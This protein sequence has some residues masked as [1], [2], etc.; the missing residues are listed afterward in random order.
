MV[1]PTARETKIYI[2]AAL[3]EKDRDAF[4]SSKLLKKKGAAGKLALKRPDLDAASGG[5]G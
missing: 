4:F 1:I 3:E 2:E 5:K